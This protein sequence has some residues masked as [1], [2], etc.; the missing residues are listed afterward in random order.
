MNLSWR[1]PHIPALIVL[2]QNSPLRGIFGNA[3]KTVSDDYQHDLLVDIHAHWLPGVDDGAKTEEEGLAMVKGLI[4]LGYHKLIATPHIM[5]E[6]YPN[7]VEHLKQVFEKF[8]ARVQSEALPVE[9][10]LGAEYMLDGGFMKQLQSG[11]L[12]TIG[13]K[14]LLIEFPHLQPFPAL[15][16]IVEEIIHRGYTPILAH[17]ERYVYYLKNR[18]A[19]DQLLDTGCQMQVNL[20]SLTGYYGKAIA[21]WSRKL[22]QSGIY[23]FAGT[24]IHNQ[25]QLEILKQYV[26]DTPF[27]NDQ[28]YR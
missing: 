16:E 21:E 27:L 4:R 22:M 3:E 9:L 20:L 6:F 26:P 24:D 19:F 17:P 13:K 5:Q 23:Q 14:D 15:K 18:K 10:E 25:G 11:E 12:L 2:W 1:I 7:T 8:A 28:F